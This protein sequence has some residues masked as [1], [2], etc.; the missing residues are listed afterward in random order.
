MLVGA[1]RARTSVVRVGWEIIYE[2]LCEC[3]YCSGRDAASEEK[4]RENQRWRFHCRNGGEG[5]QRRGEMAESSLDE[6][7][8]LVYPRLRPLRCS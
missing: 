3:G 2:S 6:L 7:P 8:G 1:V 4:E 5:K